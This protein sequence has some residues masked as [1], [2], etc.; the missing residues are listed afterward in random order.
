MGI[1]VEEKGGLS[2]DDALKCV[3]PHDLSL[4]SVNYFFDITD[5]DAVSHFFLAHADLSR[6]DLVECG[7]SQSSLAEDC[8]SI[9]VDRNKRIFD[10]VTIVSLRTG[11]KHTFK[12]GEDNVYLRPC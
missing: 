2:V 6:G 9:S 1:R 4:D 11:E 7:A 10:K 5:G 3:T 8:H 12:M